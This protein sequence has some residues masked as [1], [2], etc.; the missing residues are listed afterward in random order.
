M[1]DPIPE[2]LTA[3][4]TLTFLVGA[5]ARNSAAIEKVKERLPETS[6]DP[7]LAKVLADFWAK[8]EQYRR[9][10]NDLVHALKTVSLDDARSTSQLLRRILVQCEAL[11]ALLAN[12]GHRDR[13]LRIARGG[14]FWIDEAGAVHYVLR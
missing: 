8:E 14:G 4:Q 13:L 9:E 2:G 6:E 5:A 1:S 11:E 3:D 12:Q 7:V 10:R